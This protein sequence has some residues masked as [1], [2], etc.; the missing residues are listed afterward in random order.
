MSTT[1]LDRMVAGYVECALWVGVLSDDLSETG[2]PVMDLDSDQLSADCL[3]AIVGECDDFLMANR[4][5][6]EAYAEHYQPVGG[7]DPWECAGHDFH[8][9]RNGH[10]A[11]FWDR[12]LGQLGDRL[13][14][15]AR[16]YGETNY[17]V[18]GAGVVH[19]M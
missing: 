6:L 11:G 8:L 19:E 16:V 12:G 1:E 17:W 18:D 5:D 3:A 7:Y 14:D 10:G 4:D 2:E 15:A 13:S 9:T